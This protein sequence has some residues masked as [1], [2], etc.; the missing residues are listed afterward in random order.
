MKLFMNELPKPQVFLA[1]SKRAASLVKNFKDAAEKQNQNYDFIDWDDDP[2]DF[3]SEIF[4]KLIRYCKKCDF[5]LVFLTSDEAEELSNPS[6]LGDFTPRDNCIFELGLF[7]GVLGLDLK[8]C[9]ILSSFSVEAFDRN[10]SDLKGK[11]IH[12]FKKETAEE[13]FKNISKKINAAIES[14]SYYDGCRPN[15]FR[16]Y[17][18]EML[19]AMETVKN[20]EKNRL[21]RLRKDER[22]IVDS[23]YPL[24]FTEKFGERYARQVIANIMKNGIEYWYFFT[25]EEGYIKNYINGI[26]F[27]LTAMDEMVGRSEREQNKAYETLRNSLKIYFRNDLAILE[28]CIHNARERG[29]ESDCYLKYYGNDASAVE[30]ENFFYIQLFKGDKVKN[31]TDRYKKVLRQNKDGSRSIFPNLDDPAIEF[32]FKDELQYQL[33]RKFSK[34]TL[35]KLGV[36]V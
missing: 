20:G 6:R 1:Y 32:A 28:Y 17:R 24:E 18:S 14:L 27:M 25:A 11:L 26:D 3:D 29:G 10:F 30:N 7:C 21:A 33:S 5:V 22:V 15:D 12:S 4:D 19:M 31:M 16:I 35:Q 34:E 36:T 8:R 23:D 13:D 9:F 2:L